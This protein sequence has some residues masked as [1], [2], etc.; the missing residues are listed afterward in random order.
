NGII[1]DTVDEKSEATL[2]LAKPRDCLSQLSGSLFDAVLEHVVEPVTRLVDLFER[3]Q[4]NQH[5]HR[6]DQPPRGIVERRRIGHKR[7]TRTIWPLRYSLP[8]PDR[9]IFL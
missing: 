7:D 5:I 1:R 3:G 8:S 9:A 4:I 6:T 2:A